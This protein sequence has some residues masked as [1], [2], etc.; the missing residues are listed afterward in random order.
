MSYNLTMKTNRVATLFKVILLLSPIFFSLW[1]VLQHGVNIVF[2]DEWGVVAFYD[3]M[4]R[5]GFSFDILFAQ[6]N[7]HRIFFPRLVFLTSGIISSWN[8]VV[9]MLITQILFGLVYLCVVLWITDK[10]KNHDWIRVIFC[11]V[12]GNLFY[13]LV[14]YENFLWGFQVSFTMPLIFG[15]LSFIVFDK[16]VRTNFKSTLHLITLLG[17][18]IIASF[19]SLQGLFIWLVYFILFGLFWIFKYKIPK[20]ILLSITSVGVISMFIYLY[21]FHMVSGHMGDGISFVDILASFI[22]GT[23]G[24]LYNYYT[25]F[26]I[27]LGLFLIFSTLFIVMYILKSKQ[28]CDFIFPLSLMT[29][30]YGFVLSIALGR[31]DKFG[32]GMVF[33]SRYTTYFMLILE[34]LL[35]CVYLLYAYR[36]K[37]TTLLASG[38]RKQ[39]IVKCLFTCVV[40][41]V[42]IVSVGICLQNVILWD[43]G[44]AVN[45]QRQLGKNAVLNY[46][47]VDL[48]SLQRV[49]P[50]NSYDDAYEMIGIIEKYNYNVFSNNWLSRIL[51]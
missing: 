4:M 19:S 51:G 12:F 9:N 41:T 45:D 49:Y 37:S 35:L 15:I 47:N 38:S 21:D 26:N 22:L 14:Q 34:G 7:E 42:F 10:W 40:A 29:Y 27:L 30:G 8:V 6:H 36:N 44:D 28:L 25:P 33:S 5:N 31:I 48:T 16:L 17:Y 13:N 1:F 2:W 50:W 20:K 18:A 11:L 43:C 3:E 23:G 46:D 39:N 32:F 24:M